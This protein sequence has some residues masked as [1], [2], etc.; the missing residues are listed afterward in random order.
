[1]L[2]TLLEAL[3]VVACVILPNTDL[4]MVVSPMLLTETDDAAPVALIFAELPGPASDVDAIVPVFVIAPV[5]P[6]IWPMVP[7]VLV[8]ALASELLM[9]A[10]ET[11]DMPPVALIDTP[12]PMPETVPGE[13]VPVLVTDTGEV[14][15]VGPMLTVV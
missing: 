11:D 3:F 15:V 10:K 9:L 2:F 14:P 8:P 1:M 7:T 4:P 5:L 6:L 12:A 13:I